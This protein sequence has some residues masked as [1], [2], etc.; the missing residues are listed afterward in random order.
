MVVLACN[1]SMMEA[2]AGGSGLASEF[3]ASLEYIVIPY[4]KKNSN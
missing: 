2:E 1:P 4:L 3:T